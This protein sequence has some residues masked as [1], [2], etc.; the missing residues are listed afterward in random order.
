[1]AKEGK[2]FL[3]R[4]PGKRAF[5]TGI[6]GKNRPCRAKDL[7]G[8]VSGKKG[9][10]AHLFIASHPPIEYNKR[11]NGSYRKRKGEAK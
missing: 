9:F 4:R 3:H 2:R 1:M 5:S 10:F 6:P 7:P 8:K 11:V